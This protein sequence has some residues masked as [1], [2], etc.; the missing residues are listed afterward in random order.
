[1]DIWYH[2]NCDNCQHM[3]YEPTG[4]VRD[5]RIFDYFIHYRC[6]Y[7]NSRGV[8]KIC[9]KQINIGD[10]AD[11]RFSMEIHIMTHYGI[12]EFNVTHDPNVAY[13][14]IFDSVNNYAPY[15]F[16]LSR[17]ESIYDMIFYVSED[18]T[19]TDDFGQ[20]IMSKLLSLDHICV[21]CLD[22][23]GAF[24]TIE[25][26]ISHLKQKHGLIDSQRVDAHNL[27]NCPYNTFKSEPC[28]IGSYITTCDSTFHITKIGKLPPIKWLLSVP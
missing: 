2:I 9:K 24:P 21:I 13:K 11:D 16:L 28:Y 27:L 18:T 10:S 4:F 26:I 23:Y 6:A 19:K 8:C 15:L 22:D 14:Y 5:K 25:I 1:M 17:H 3:L 7:C 20:K 12:D